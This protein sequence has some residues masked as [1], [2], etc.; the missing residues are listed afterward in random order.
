MNELK[1]VSI[2]YSNPKEGRTFMNL[3]MKRINEHLA[4]QKNGY[5]ANAAMWFKV[6]LWLGAWAATYLLIISGYFT[7]WALLGMAILH[8]F[9]HL[10]IAFNISH[11]AN[12]N[13]LSKNASVNKFFSYSLDL[14]G[15]NSFLWRLAHNDEH[16][17][18]INYVEIDNNIN[19][20]G[21]VR[22]SPDDKIRKNMFKYQHLYAPLVYGLVTLNYVTYKDFKLLGDARRNGVEIPAKEIF[23]LVFFKAFFYLYVFIIPLIMLPITFGQLLLTVVIVHFLLGIVLS[24][25]FQCGHITEG[26]HYPEIHDDQIPDS[27]AVHVVKTTCDYGSKNSL[28]TWLVGGINIH[29]IH[30]L[31]PYI[32]HTHYQSLVPVLKKTVEEYGLEYREHDS[33]TSAIVSHLKMLK[34][35]GNEEVIPA[36]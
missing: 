31:C 2:T 9:T 23:L 16:H 18:Y 22:F 17:G 28:L 11:D 7:G 26:A 15:V 27:W 29:A 35:V 4:D 14:I 10:F 20:Y 13:A 34:A 12:H 1:H 6:F 24:L 19:G 21:V 32:C 25:V 36:A 8:G 30:H 5:H 3:L 33:F